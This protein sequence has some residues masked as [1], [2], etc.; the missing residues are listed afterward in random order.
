LNDDDIRDLQ[1][2]FR[3][4]WFD[5]DLRQTDPDL[6]RLISQGRGFTEADK[7]TLDEIE[8]EALRK[9]LPEYREAAARGQVEISMTPYYHPILPLLVDSKIRRDGIAGSET[10]WNSFSVIR[11]MHSIRSPRR[12]NSTV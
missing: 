9:V 5:Y 8:R 4:C 10:A 12:Q 6:Q 1:V 7:E 3:L 2:W 11:K